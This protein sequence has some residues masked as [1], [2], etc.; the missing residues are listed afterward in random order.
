M[1][2][3]VRT[4]ADAQARSWISAFG[5]SLARQDAAAVG[6]T[7]QADSHWRNLCGISWQLATFSG[8][9]KLSDELCRRSREVG[10]TGFE[11]DAKLLLPRNAVVA[12]KEV[13]E[14][15][16]RFDTVNGPGL[17]V[18]RLIPRHGSDALPQAWTISTLLDMEKISQAKSNTGARGSPDGYFAKLNWLD[19]RR[20]EVAFENREP[21]VLV[22]GGGHA[23]ISAAVELKRIGLDTL[24]IDKQQRVGDNWRLRYNGLKLH[25]KTP[26]NHLRYMPFP[27]TWPDYIPKDKIAN[28]L[29][30]YVESMDVNFWTKT[31]LE[32]AEYDEATQ[33]WTAKVRRRWQRSHAPSEAYRDGDQRQRHAQHSE[34]RDHRKFCG[35]DPAFEQ[36]LRR[37]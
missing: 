22:V 10:A 26:V 34:G 20:S 33:S 28:W 30:T 16:F 36:V 18:V 15:I 17:G 11:L 31:T 9:R 24:V 2:E 1:L 37:R 19:Q 5:H 3:K 32:G 6:Q 35:K 27:P 12:G 29:E 23:G 4:S 25:N 8:S 13:I 7:F 21:D 14:A